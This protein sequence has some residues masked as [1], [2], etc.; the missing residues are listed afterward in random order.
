[1]GWF[2]S[3]GDYAH[4]IDRDRET[5]GEQLVVGVVSVLE[6]LQLAGLG[7][8]VVGDFDFG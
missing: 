8:V 3:A 2:S 5:G 7:A 4:G 1:M 6:D